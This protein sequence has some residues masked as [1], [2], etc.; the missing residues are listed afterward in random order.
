[1]ESLEHLT[2]KLERHKKAV[3]AARWA[4]VEEEASVVASMTSECQAAK[5]A[6]I[7]VVRKE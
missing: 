5:K 4:E 6:V 3:K 2:S 7:S 1:M